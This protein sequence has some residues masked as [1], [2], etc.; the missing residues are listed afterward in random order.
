MTADTVDLMRRK[1]PQTRFQGLEQGQGDRRR[2]DG[3]R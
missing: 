2:L 1:E 3:R